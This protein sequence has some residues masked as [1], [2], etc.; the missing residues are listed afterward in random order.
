MC[1]ILL[2]YKSHPTYHLVV[3][4][5]RDEYYRRPTRPLSFWGRNPDILAGQDLKDG[6]TWL[7]ITRTGRFAAITNYREPHTYHADSPSRGLLIRRFLEDNSDPET[8]LKKIDFGK[9]IYNGF[10]MLAGDQAALYY[11]S[12]RKTGNHPG[13]VKL[14]PGIYGLSNRFLDT[15]WPKVKNG[16]SDLQT[17]LKDECHVQVESIFELLSDRSQ[18][19]DSDLPDTG[20]GIAWE[21]ILSPLFI[22]SDHYGTR[23]S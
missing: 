1:L 23:S 17:L 9:K 13:A 11:L 12:N 5:N 16:K 18:P 21:R 14:E 2:S 8:C 20:V 10:N 15:P 7:G 22:T 19:P 6:G 4:A 3:A